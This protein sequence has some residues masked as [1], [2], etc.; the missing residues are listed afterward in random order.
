MFFT[1]SK[2]DLTTAVDDLK[3]LLDDSKKEV[4]TLLA[5]P[6]KRYESF[7]RPYQYIF[8]KIEWFYTPLSILNSTKNEETIQ[9]VYEAMLP[10]LSEFDSDVKQNPALFD[11]FKTIHANEKSLTDAQK[12]LLENE[13]LDFELSGAS[14]PADKQARMKTIKSRLSQLSN[15]FSQNVLNATNAY[16]L[17]LESDRDIQEMP[18]SDRK[19]AETTLEGKTVYRFTLKGPSFSAFMTY[20]SN[21]QLR[22][23]M[24]KAYTTRAPENDA[25]M[26]EILAL[27]DEKAKLLGFENYAQL[28][29]ETKMA[30]SPEEVESFLTELAT[31]SL[32]QAKK[33]LETLR[34]FAK[35]GECVNLQSF[36]TGY[37]SKKLEK[38][39]FDL[40]EELYR[41]YF[42]KQSVVNGLFE[43]LNNFFKITFEK[44]DEEAWDEKV[45]AYILKKEGEPFAKI[46]MDLESR[47]DKQGGAWMGDW[48]THA[49]TPEGKTQLPI[50]YIVCNFAPSSEATP[51]L[52]KHDD[53]V[54]LFHEMGHALHHLFSRVEEPFVSG[55]AGVEWDA[56]EFPSQFLENFAYEPQVLKMFAKHYQNGELLP[57]AM[58]DKLIDAKNFQSALAMLRQLEF[59]LF[60]IRIHKA[61]HNAKEVQGIL[62]DVRK[63]TALLTPPDYN[64][65][66]H[67]FTHIF[68]GGYAAGYYSYKWAEVLSADAFYCFVDNG[69]FH[70]DTAKAYIDNVL[71]QGGSRTAIENFTAFMGREPDPTALIRLSG[72]A[73]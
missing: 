2:P 29:L 43:F 16:E 58:I 34:T 73:S 41:P 72:I 55:I 15:T 49:K 18:E 42:E 57:D 19:Q 10:L 36:D 51:S 59:G 69:I 38:A 9:K 65:F 50:A 8:E 64:R 60:D 53:V 31:Q 24:Y 4:E 27:R 22:E 20:C 68:S 48:R 70:D 67:G 5:E 6:E 44:S 66:Q 56:V 54:T 1:Y 35:S 40:D 28:S 39:T 3:K 61:L 11:A 33:E 25:I 71:S 45:D 52:L 47:E 37:Y 23:Q 26:E 14:L 46:Y 21:S 63:T 12:K 7:V 13:I 32:P 30:R 17:I 62:D